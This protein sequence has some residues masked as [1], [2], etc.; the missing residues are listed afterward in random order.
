MKNASMLYVNIY[1]L[2]FHRPKFFL[3]TLNKNLHVPNKNGLKVA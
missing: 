2:I 3:S 1:K